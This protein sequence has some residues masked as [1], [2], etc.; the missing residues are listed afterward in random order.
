[1]VDHT[2]DIVRETERCG[3]DEEYPDL[4]YVARP[5]GLY[6]TGERVDRH[7]S[8]EREGSAM[9]VAMIAKHTVEDYAAWKA[10]YDSQ[11][12]AIREQGGVIAHQV[13]RDLDDPSW[14]TVY[15]QFPDEATARAY[16]GMFDS[17]EFRALADQSGIDV[18]SMEISLL[19]EVD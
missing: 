3:V 10:G 12:V 16:S 6:R 4:R 19:A 14:V 1:M 7:V 8:D 18:A 2:A 9:T 15:H 13:Y 11:G 17:D 5:G